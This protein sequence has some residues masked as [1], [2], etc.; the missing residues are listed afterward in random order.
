MISQL[1]RLLSLESVVESP[2]KHLHEQRRESSTVRVL[3]GGRR[4]DYS[5]ARKSARLSRCL[6][7]RKLM[8]VAFRFAVS[9]LVRYL[10]LEYILIYVCKIY[11]LF[12]IEKDK[13][14][15]RFNTTGILY[16]IFQNRKKL[17]R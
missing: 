3:M 8:V 10:R 17:V 5:P 1:S 4:K 7:E 14:F 15:T 2:L 9:D 6:K 11:R 16:N 13:D 12:S